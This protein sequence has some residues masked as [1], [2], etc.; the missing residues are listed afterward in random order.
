MADPAGTTS[1]SAARY[2]GVR[3]RKWGKWVSEVRLP[4]SRERIWLGSYDSP[5]KA[6]R[7]FDAGSFLLRGG[8]ASLNFP[9]RKQE[10]AVYCGHR[11]PTPQQIQAAA[12]R[13]AH[14]EMPAPSEAAPALVAAEDLAPSPAM[15]EWELMERLMDPTFPVIDEFQYGLFQQEEQLEQMD[16]DMG[17]GGGGGSYLWNF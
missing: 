9:D 14:A 13:Y 10:I 8:R 1:A 11:N 6:A 4:N 16:V 15:S 2:K 12:A 17:G 5:E 3:K 7:A